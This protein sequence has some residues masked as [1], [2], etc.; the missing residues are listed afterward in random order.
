MKLKLYRYVHRPLKAPE[1]RSD[2]IRRTGNAE[3]LVGKIQDKTASDLEERLA[4]GLDKLKV[5]Y[6]F[7]ARIS[8][9]AVGGQ[10]L[11]STVRNII[12]ELEIDHLIY[13]NQIIPVL[14][15]G[16]IGHF[17]TKYQ[18]IQ[19]AEKINAINEFGSTQNWHEVVEVPYTEL[20]TQDAADS[21]ARRIVNGVYIPQFA[22]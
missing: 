18:R 10:H 22:G 14:V 11:T 5:A 8:S 1:F 19:D 16:E 17:F 4:K 2:G 15:Q 21:V 12:G 3:V 9:A 6:E 13:N 20:K 7:R